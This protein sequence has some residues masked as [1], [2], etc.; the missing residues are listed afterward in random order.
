[1]RV[2]KELAD[3]TFGDVRLSSPTVIRLTGKG[4]KA[5]L[6]PIMVPTE[7]LLRAYLE[8][9]DPNYL[10]HSGYPLFC[11]RDGRKLTRAGINVIKLSQCTKNPHQKSCILRLALWLFQTFGAG[12]FDQIS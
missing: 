3:L 12:F 2:Y 1:M 8:E 5:R 10:A 4:S 6:V 9:H 11:N 7:K